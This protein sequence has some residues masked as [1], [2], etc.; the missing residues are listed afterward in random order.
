MLS[1]VFSDQLFVVV[2]VTIFAQVR[3]AIVVGDVAHRETE[4]VLPEVLTFYV[5]HADAGCLLDDFL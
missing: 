4:T 3:T 1:E 2:C 5:Q